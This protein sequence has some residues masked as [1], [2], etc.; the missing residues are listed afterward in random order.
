ME[1]KLE[2]EERILTVIELGEAIFGI[3]VQSER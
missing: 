1:I 2:L 3:K